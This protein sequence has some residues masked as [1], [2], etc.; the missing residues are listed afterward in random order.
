MPPA[1]SG[2]ARKKGTGGEGASNL[3]GAPS[4][5]SRHADDAR[6]YP[7]EHSQRRIPDEG[8]RTTRAVF[9]GQKPV[10]TRHSWNDAPAIACNARGTPRNHAPLAI[11]Q[12]AF[13]AIASTLAL[14][15][16][17]F[18]NKT[19]EHG[20]RLVW[21]PPEVVDRLRALCGAWVKATAT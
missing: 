14:G 2:N 19:D 1:P 18:E 12:A 9:S 16:T 13:D 4:A 5:P 8:W 10:I 3:R 17:G 21:L 6:K 20:N 11:S 7:F 15:S